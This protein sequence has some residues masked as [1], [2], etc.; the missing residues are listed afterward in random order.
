[1]TPSAAER[2]FLWEAVLAPLTLISFD[3]TLSKSRASEFE[4]FLLFNKENTGGPD[5]TAVDTPKGSSLII[6]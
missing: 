6:R 3:K 5:F 4:G 1:M 2:R